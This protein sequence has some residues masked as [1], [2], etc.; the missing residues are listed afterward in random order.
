MLGEG[1]TTLPL[2][3][4]VSVPDSMSLICQWLWPSPAQNIVVPVIGTSVDPLASSNAR[5]LIVRSL[6][7]VFGR[8]PF[9]SNGPEPT[10]TIRAS[11]RSSR[12]PGIVV[13]S[14]VTLVT[15]AI[16]IGQELRLRRRR[17]PPSPTDERRARYEQGTGRTYQASTHG[18]PF[19][20][21]TPLVFS[22]VR[23]NETLKDRELGPVHFG[24]SKR[25][26]GQSP[27]AS[28]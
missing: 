3:R 2:S 18:I 11:Y 17:R 26:F 24:W 28:S 19:R 1:P 21:A 6:T 20:S 27:L 4:R 10:F 12:W 14:I 5:W 9:A 23:E 7:V 15:G 22:A 13:V 25:T 16:P 8:E